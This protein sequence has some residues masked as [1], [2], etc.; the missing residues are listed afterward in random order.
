MSKQVT[1]KR[2]G[3]AGYERAVMVSTHEGQRLVS[4]EYIDPQREIE[5]AT[6]R[7]PERCYC[8]ADFADG[9]RASGKNVI[10]DDQRTGRVHRRENL[11]P[12]SFTP[13]VRSEFYMFGFLW[14]LGQWNNF[15]GGFAR[16]VPLR[17]Q[18]YT[19]ESLVASGLI[20]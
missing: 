4:V 19:L 15:K 17:K 3:K 12:S 13:G 10:I 2:R 8:I 14:G 16:G 18:V 1:I 7:L 20:K 6:G 11:P 9:V 5:L